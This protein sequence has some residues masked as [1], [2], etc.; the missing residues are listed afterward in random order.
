MINGAWTT[1]SKIRV[2]TNGTEYTIIALIFAVAIL[3]ISVSLAGY[4]LRREL[5]FVLIVAYSIFATFGILV[6]SGVILKDNGAC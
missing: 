6:E 2:F 1:D 4:Q 5:G 3:Y